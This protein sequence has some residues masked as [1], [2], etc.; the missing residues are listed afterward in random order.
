LLLISVALAAGGCQPLT[1]RE[2]TGDDEYRPDPSLA[3][4]EQV[5]SALELG[6]FS[7][8]VSQ[9]FSPRERPDP[10]AARA[11]ESWVRLE[12]GR[13]EEAVQ[14]CVASAMFDPLSASAYASVAATAPRLRDLPSHQLRA[15]LASWEAAGLHD[16]SLRL[17]ESY[18]MAGTAYVLSLEQPCEAEVVADTPSPGSYAQTWLVEIVDGRIYAMTY[19]NP[20]PGLRLDVIEP[21]TGARTKVIDDLRSSCIAF[22]PGAASIA[23]STGGTD[24][25][26]SPGE[27]RSVMVMDLSTRQPAAIATVLAPVSSM[28]WSP[29]M[30]H[31]AVASYEGVQLIGVSGGDVRL[32]VPAINREDPDLFEAPQV[33][34]WSAD[35]RAVLYQWHLYERCGAVEAYDVETGR[36]TKVLASGPGGAELGLASPSPD[37]RLLAFSWH[38]GGRSW[39]LAV[40][41]IRQGAATDV[42]EVTSGDV[43]SSFA[44]WSPDG[45]YL[46]YHAG[47]NET[48]GTWLYDLKDGARRLLPWS[49]AGRSPKWGDGG[50]LYFMADD[51]RLLALR[52]RLP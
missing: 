8:V 23:Y 43:E 50:V 2:S 49:C 44:G 41:D 34:G 26:A 5:L 19:M 31:I 11:V 32:L 4:S 45:R 33:L 46:A 48:G 16:P 24:S 12:R 10:A 14:L 35:G 22:S 36:V 6:Q 42:S 40:A 9:A 1:P 3:F 7:W 39:L 37:G 29:S 30:E 47:I 25:G 27:L 20:G 38:P 51:E 52:P 28:A 18:R 21:R 17:S 15:A 13:L